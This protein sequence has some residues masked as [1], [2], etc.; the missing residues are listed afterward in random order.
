M[1]PEQQQMVDRP[2]SSVERLLQ[3]GHVDL[4]VQAGWQ[5]TAAL[6]H[7][8]TSG[9]GGDDLTVT[10]RPAGG[11]DLGL[12]L[13]DMLGVAMVRKAAGGGVAAQAGVNAPADTRM[14]LLDGDLEDRHSDLRREKLCPVS[15]LYTYENFD[16]AIEIVRANIA[17]DGKGH[18]VSIHSHDDAHIEQLGLAADVTRVIVNQCATT[19]AGGS[20]FNGFGS[21]T[22]LGT[23]FWGNTLLRGNLGYEDLLNIT[24]IGYRVDRP[25]PTDEQ[26]WG[27]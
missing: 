11:E 22:T 14:L 18:S 16:E 12:D 3:A 15:L 4:A 5:G 27:E 20:F 2:S 19:S 23:G 17:L 26:I 10:L 6:H 21:T 7:L 9:E 24:R 8:V 25:M 1:P 13:T